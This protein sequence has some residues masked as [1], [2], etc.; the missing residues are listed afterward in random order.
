MR[1]WTQA[2]VGVSRH[3]GLPELGLLQTRASGSQGFVG[4]TGPVV[5]WMQLRVQLWVITLSASPSAPLKGSLREDWPV[6]P[7]RPPPRAGPVPKAEASLGRS[8]GT[9]KALEVVCSETRS[10][11]SRAW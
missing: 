9:G 6:S 3:P 1:A 2:E 4:H 8:R 7:S 5:A 10:L 11:D